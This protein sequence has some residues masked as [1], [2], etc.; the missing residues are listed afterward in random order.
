MPDKGK[1][2]RDKGFL[3]VPVFARKQAWKAFEASVLNEFE[4]LTMHHLKKIMMGG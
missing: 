3:G 2:S 1:F 4:F